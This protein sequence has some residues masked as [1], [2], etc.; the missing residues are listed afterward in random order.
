MSDGISCSHWG[1]FNAFDDEP[2]VVLAD[3]LADVINQTSPELVINVSQ[4][5]P[6][7][8]TLNF[9]RLD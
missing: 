8:Q 4:K 7:Y 2:P 1:V 9:G 3:V 6:V 5:K